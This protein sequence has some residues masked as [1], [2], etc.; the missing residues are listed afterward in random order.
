MMKPVTSRIAAKGAS[1]SFTLPEP[2]S[3]F[4][5]STMGALSGGAMGGLGGSGSGG[6][7]GSGTG[8]GT[9]GGMGPGMGGA[10]GIGNPFGMLNPNAGAL[11]GAFYDLKQTDDKKPTGMSPEQHRIFLREFTSGGWKERDL[12][13][14]YQAKSKVYQTKV[15][16][17][18][19]DANAAPSAFKCEKEVEPSRWVVV[20][21]GV[22]S[23]PKTGRY[24]FVGGADDVIVIRFDNKH[25]FDHGWSLGTIGMHHSGAG[26]ALAGE[27]GDRETDRFVKKNYPME[28][29]LTFYQY[30]TT[31]NYNTAVRGLAVGPTFSAKAGDSYPIEILISEIPG[32]RF[33][34]SLLIEEIGAKYEKDS[35]D[36]SPIL[37]LFRLDEGQPKLPEGSD[38]PP[39]DPNGPIWKLVRS[40]GPEI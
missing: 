30:S 33:C 3:S 31:K 1:S 26:K 27:S 16:I 15:Y 34:A 32:G 28:N 22:V 39:Y 37:P 19:M 8:A 38:A 9:G 23:P 2:D 4:G 17:P 35:L 36:G 11:V 18:L 25:V 40:G 29:P 14:Y 10:G 5:M 13:K 24:R 21:R 6:G 7:F 12:A 20:Y